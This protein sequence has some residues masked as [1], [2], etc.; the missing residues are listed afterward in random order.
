MKKYL[1][2]LN[3]L[4]L[5][6]AFTSCGLDEAADI[7]DE[8]E[9]S[10]YSEELEVTTEEDTKEEIPESS[11]S[12]PEDTERTI[13]ID[14]SD[15]DVTNVKKVAVKGEFSEDTYIRN[16]YGSNV[17]HSG[18]V[19]LFGCPID[20][21]SLDFT[22]GTLVFEYDPDNMNNVPPENL[23]LLHYNDID[24]SYDT[25]ESEL[26][27]EKNLV[28]ANI[29]GPGVYLLADAFEWYGVWGEDV[30]QYSH[31]H[32][33][34][35]DTY[36]FKI[37][38]PEEIVL[39]Y[40]SS[41]IEDDEDGKCQTLLECKYNPNIQ[42]GIEWLERPNYASA[43]NF[44]EEIAEI[45][46]ESGYLIST[47][48][49]TASSGTVGYYFYSDFGYTVSEHSYSISCIYPIDNTHYINVWYG[50]TNEI[51]YD[52]VINSYESFEW[53]ATD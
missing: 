44:V 46:D 43:Q 33:Y 16:L 41:Y 48:S 47:G 39:Q 20:I 32:I 15:A 18:V 2:L 37:T 19:G 50:F 28:R 14:L 35:D 11:A 53:I 7:T 10:S 12:E 4:L 52:N 38:I 49:L 25:I 42:V 51:Y 21:H 24:G 23:I 17:L 5:L 45:L 13:G 26:N 31:D 30:S 6:T 36:N 27:T 34:T 3:A 22:S 29:D 1:I 9:E 8:S 40:V